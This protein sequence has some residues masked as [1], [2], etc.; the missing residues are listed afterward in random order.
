MANNKNS[1]NNGNINDYGDNFYSN[2]QNN[3]N[4]TNLNKTNINKTNHSKKSPP[5]NNR[6]KRKRK[7]T[8]KKILKIIFSLILI[9]LLFFGMYSAI[10][11]SRVKYSTQNPDSLISENRGVELKSRDGIEN[12]LIFGADN[13]K[14]E[15]YGRSDTI[16]LLT[17][18]KNKHE[19]KQTSFMRDLYLPI[20]D[21]GYYKLNAAYAYGGAKLACETIEY[22]FGI[23]IDK[24]IIF[25][26]SSFT[27]IID[28]IGGIDLELTAEEIDYINWQC[29]RNKQVETRNEMD[30]ESYTFYVNADGSA[31]AKVHLNG[32]QALWYARDRDS[33]GSDFDRTKRQRTVVNTV[34]DKMKSG[35]I[36]S[37]L[38][39]GYAASPYLTTN[40]QPLSLIGTAAETAAALNYERDEHRIPTDD[41][42]YN[43]WYDV[44][45]VLCIDD[46]ELEKERL[47]EFVFGSSDI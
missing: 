39:A 20:P 25:D 27:E 7:K 9:V 33:E 5:K 3:I 19:L 43:A 41:N 8:A 15:E 23:K 11:L 2:E 32:R 38:K 36:I 46:D 12:I 22:N 35:D 29:W 1:N 31:V 18:D 30:I 37:T 44:G 28:S 17:I 42:Y 16:I 34:L 13:P 6:R 21:Y 45:Q 24:Y 10:V 40:I 14:G 4:K 26:F 47:Y